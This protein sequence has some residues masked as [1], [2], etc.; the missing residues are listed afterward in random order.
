M[1]GKTGLILKFGHHYNIISV[2][3]CV[4]TNFGKISGNSEYL[5][6]SE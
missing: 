2:R 5:L 6:P 4:P 1:I 3:K